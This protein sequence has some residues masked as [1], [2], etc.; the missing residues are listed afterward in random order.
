[1]RRALTLLCS[2]GIAWQADAEVVVLPA[3]Q[4]A[5]LIESPDGSLANGAGPVFFAG[6]T[7]Q[8]SASVRRALL[9]FDVAGALPGGAQVTDVWLEFSLTPSNPQP[10]TL[11]LHRLT[12]RWGEG[13][14][15]SSGGS[16]TAAGSG[17]STWFHR[18]YDT[19]AWANPGGDFAP[20]ASAVTVVSGAGAYTWGSTPELVADVQDW[21]DAPDSNHGWALSGGEEA[22]STAKR[23]DSRESA[24]TQWHARGWSWSFKM[25]VWPPA[26]GAAP[27]GS[28][29]PTARSSTVMA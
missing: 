16:G 15:A 24:Q 12:A 18:F 3:I 4:D 21:L 7:G 27:S 10:V 1:M 8:S 11:G 19:H 22:P 23:F 20:A 5:T 6:R 14:A 13:T 25:P 2:I 28:A 29:T 26:S 17:D 9:L